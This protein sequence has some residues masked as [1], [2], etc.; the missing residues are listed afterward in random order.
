[1]EKEISSD[2]LVNGPWRRAYEKLSVNEFRPG[3][4]RQ[5]HIVRNRLARAYS[6]CENHRDIILQL[7]LPINDPPANL[8]EA[9]RHERLAGR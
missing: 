9:F 7:H 6:S 2:L 3:V 5:T 4:F 1:M 8:R